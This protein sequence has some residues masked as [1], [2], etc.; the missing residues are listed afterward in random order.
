MQWSDVT[1]RPPPQQLRQ[2]AMLCLIV[3]GGLAAWRGWTGSLGPI[4]QALLGAGIAVGL[5]GMVKPLW[6]RPIFTG[7][8]IVAFPIGWVV[9][10][11]ILGAMYYLVFTPM[12][13]AF[14]L[15]RRDALRLRRPAGASYWLTREPSSDAKS[16]FRQF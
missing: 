5:V 10:R 3:F 16:Y 9:S 12:A 8:M 15:L 14:R 11:V 2:F 13:V 6:V 1:R 7:W 4:S